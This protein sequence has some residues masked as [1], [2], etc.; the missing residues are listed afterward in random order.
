[1][2]DYLVGIARL[3]RKIGPVDG[4]NF[5]RE[6][7]SPTLHKILVEYLDSAIASRKILLTL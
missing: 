5:L 4:K 1:M 2:P 6:W 7:S 3:C